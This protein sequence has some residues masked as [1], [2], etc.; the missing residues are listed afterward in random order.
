MGHALN[1]VLCDNSL[2][3]M[4]GAR[5]PL[6]VVELPSHI[7]QRAC[8]DPAVL[9]DLLSRTGRAA[10]A[11]DVAAAADALQARRTFC[12]SIRTLEDLAMPSLDAML[13]GAEPPSTVAELRQDWHSTLAALLPYRVPEAVLPHLSINHVVTYGGLC[14]AYPYSDA[15]AATVWEHVLCCDAYNREGGHILADR[16]FRPGGL[17][18]PVSVLNSLAPGALVASGGGHMPGSVVVNTS[19]PVT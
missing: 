17:L 5:G 4:F 11:G 14:H 19:L 10:A 12:S 9:R 6:D 8:D 7:L 16:V 18:D 13:H 2:Q 15:L 1:S 3:H